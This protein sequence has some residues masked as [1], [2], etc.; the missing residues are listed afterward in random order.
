MSDAAAEQVPHDGAENV[1]AAV[2]TGAREGNGAGATRY[3]LSSGAAVDGVFFSLAASA[4]DDGSVFFH[5]VKVQEAGEGA[6][7]A[8]KKTSEPDN[9]HYFAKFNKVV[10][11]PEY[12]DREYDDLLRDPEWTKEETDLL[13]SLCRRF[14]LR[15]VVIAD[16]FEPPPD[17]PKRS[18]EDLKDRYYRR[19]VDVL[20]SRAKEQVDEEESIF[21]ELSRLQQHASRYERDRSAL[22]HLL[23]NP[24]PNL[25]ETIT[26]PPSAAGRG[27]SPGPAPAAGVTAGLGAA[28]EA[29]RNR[30]RPWQDVDDDQALQTPVKKERRA[31]GPSTGR[32]EEFATPFAQ[33]AAPARSSLAGGP[34]PSLYEGTPESSSTTR[35]GSVHTPAER[36]MQ[37]GVTTARTAVAFETLYHDLQQ[38][39]ETQRLAERLE[40][41]IQTWREKTAALGA[42]GATSGADASS[43]S[44]LFPG[45]GWRRRFSDRLS[46][47]GVRRLPR[48]FVVPYDRLPDG[49]PSDKAQESRPKEKPLAPPE[50]DAF[51]AD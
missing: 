27:E 39:V 37:H 33:S 12:T 23:H 7:L 9:G 50:M 38:L 18:L 36:R 47:A 25:Q 31:V 41:E 49:L 42:A 28:G 51:L 35:P 26:I 5:W 48:A 17:R 30:K 22:L 10:D 1:R 4:R 15:F 6:G 19:R 45:V 34:P 3:E 14:D 2:E 29:G 40:T 24:D 21:L 11:V 13:F 20:F 32:G 44:T 43:F 16:R 46:A 8:R